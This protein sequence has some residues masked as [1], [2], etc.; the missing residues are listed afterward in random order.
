[1][2]DAKITYEGSKAIVMMC[3]RTF[4]KEAILAAA[5]QLTGQYVVDVKDTEPDNHVVICS[6]DGNPVELLVIDT[7][8]NNCLDEQLRILLEK[9]SGMIRELIVEHAFKPLN[10][11]KAL[12][13]VD[14]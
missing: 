12:E 3:G 10:L 14:V 5:Y 6:K 4:S 1:M 8:L 2:M 13:T 7:F 11:K 9:R